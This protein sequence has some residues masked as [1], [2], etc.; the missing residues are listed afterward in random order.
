MLRSASDDVEQVHLIGGLPDE[1]TVVFMTSSL[2]DPT[3]V[4][5]QATGGNSAT[6]T[7]LG[8]TNVHSSMI[9]PAGWQGYADPT[10]PFPGTDYQTCSQIHTDYRRGYMNASCYYTS[11]YV[12]TVVL[13]GLKP[14]TR[15]QY[16]P[17]TSTQWRN[18]TTPPATGKAVKL[19]VVADLGQT[20]DSLSTMKNMM[21]EVEKDGIN[22]VLFPGDLSYADGFMPAWD[23]FGRLSQFLFQAVPTAYGV[24]NHEFNTGAENFGSF[25]PRYGWTATARSRSPSPLWFSYETGLAHVIMLC[26]YCGFASGG[27]QK[28]W[29]QK[30]LAAVNRSRTPWVVAAWHTPWYTTNSNHK[31]QEGEEMRASLEDIIYAHKVDVVFNGHVHAYERTMPVY[32]NKSQ[33]D[34]P[35]HITIG[36]GGNKEGPACPW[37]AGDFGWTEIR[38]FSFGFGVLNLVNASHGHWAWHRNQDNASVYADSVWFQPTQLRCG[39]EPQDWLEVMV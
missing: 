4:V 19:G 11:D 21:A 23:T 24:G 3:V 28:D 35:I 5:R 38:E 9:Q 17:G 31:M 39:P 27:A 37:V 10:G 36:D 26:S 7:F 12:H 1:V 8:V 16:L 22:A 20:S 15:Y 32:Q 2:A 30:D 25:L 14:A 34:G 18:F 29:L 6:A 33:C 13:S